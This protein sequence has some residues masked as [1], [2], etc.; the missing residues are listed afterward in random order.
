MLC[1]TAAAVQQSIRFCRELGADYVQFSTLTAMPG[2]EITTQFSQR[3]SVKNPLD[4]D[5]YR[6]TISD[7]PPDILQYIRWNIADGLSVQISV[8]RIFDRHSL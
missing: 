6:E 7:I 1:C 2:T 8:K 4:R 5:L 3:M